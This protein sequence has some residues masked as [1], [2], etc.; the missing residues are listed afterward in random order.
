ML[1]TNQTE[2]VEVALSL[3]REVKREVIDFDYPKAVLLTK[4]SDACDQVLQEDLPPGY[5]PPTEEWYSPESVRK[6]LP[7]PTTGDRILG[8]LS[9]IAGTSLLSTALC[10]CIALSSWGISEFKSASGLK[11]STDYAAETRGYRGLSFTFLG[12]TLA[13]GVLGSVIGDAVYRGNE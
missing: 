11:T 9:W 12:I 6:S 2:K 5:I 1:T 10:A 3:I 13:C 4:A 8:V 7:T